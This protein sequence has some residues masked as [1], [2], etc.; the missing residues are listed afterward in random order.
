MSYKLPDELI[1]LT[2]AKA[3]QKVTTEKMDGKVC[4]ISGAT[5][6]VGLE[7]LKAILKAGG[8]C[9]IVARNL[10]KAQN[11]KAQVDNDYGVNIDI[12]IS[13]FSSF[14]SVRAAAKEISTKYPVI[15]VL[16]NSAGLFSTRRKLTKD[17]NE[18][19]FQVNHLSTLLFTWLLLDNIKKSA[20]GRIVQVNSEGHRFGGFNINDLT[21]KKRPYMGLRGYGAS[22]IA[23]I[24]TVQQMANDLKDTNVTINTMHPGAVKT[25]LGGDNGWLYRTYNK[26]FIAPSMDDPKISGSAIYYLVA[27]KS[28]NQISGKFFDLTILEPPASY[29]MNRKYYDKIYPLSKKLCGIID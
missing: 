7:A 15:D 1:F 27:D 17:G 24:I 2:N 28:L 3:T 12:I 4:I 19:V 16:I 23:Q 21:W 22:K 6:G 14:D 10:Q 8:K 20:Q 26:Y 13:D 9:I 5:S 25:N 11:I 29:V 18:L